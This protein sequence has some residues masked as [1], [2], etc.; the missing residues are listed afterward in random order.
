MTALRNAV[1]IMLIITTIFTESF[2]RAGVWAMLLYCVIV[3]GAV[4]I[5]TRPRGKHEKRWRPNE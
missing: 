3:V 5:I 4:L 2:A 1:G